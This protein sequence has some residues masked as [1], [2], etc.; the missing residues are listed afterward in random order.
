[1]WRMHTNASIALGNNNLT[2]T[3]TIG[4]ATT[5][6]ELLNPPSGAQF[7][8]MDA[9]R[10]LTDPPTPTGWPDQPNPGVLV[11]VIGL[12]AGNYT[13]EVLFNPQWPGMSSSSYVQPNSV[14]LSQW[15]LTSHP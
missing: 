8:I 15:S 12:P 2:A 7:S 9:E 5:V 11:L 14:P 4:S 6:V 3:L 1:M 13:L 10:L